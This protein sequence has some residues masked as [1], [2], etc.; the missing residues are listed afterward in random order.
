[1]VC[2]MQGKTLLYYLF[3]QPLLVFWGEPTLSALGPLLMV[4]GYRGGFPLLLSTGPLSSLPLV[5]S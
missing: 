1:M 4:F 5:C 2:Y 3:S